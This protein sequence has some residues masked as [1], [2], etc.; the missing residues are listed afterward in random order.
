[1]TNSEAW[2]DGD[3][4]IYIKLDS[5]SQGL[6][7]SSDI[8]HLQYYIEAAPTPDHAAAD[9]LWEVVKNDQDPSKLGPTMPTIGEHLTVYG[10]Y[11]YDSLHSYKELH[12]LYGIN[13]KWA[14]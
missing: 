12:R 7:S 9:M 3:W 8:T 14:P 4:D 10:A 13:G 6:V 5:G 11:D 1:V 2:T